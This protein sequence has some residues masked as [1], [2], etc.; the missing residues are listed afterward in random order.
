MT[1]GNF[2]P[3]KVKTFALEKRLILHSPGTA[4]NCVSAKSSDMQKN[5]C[6]FTEHQ[7]TEGRMHIF[8]QNRSSV[9]Q[10]Y[11]EVYSVNSYEI[12]N[13]ILFLKFNRNV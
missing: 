4:E 6:L 5:S 11:L 10:N 9:F 7:S 8:S 2:Q 1:W 12:T 13:K 3:S